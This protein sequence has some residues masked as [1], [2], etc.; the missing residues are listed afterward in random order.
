MA[1]AYETV[2]DDPAAAA[3]AERPRGDLDKSARERVE[4]IEKQRAGARDILGVRL[5]GAPDGDVPGSG[6]DAPP[7]TSLMTFGAV[8]FT[9]RLRGLA[10]F[11]RVAEYR[12]PLIERVRLG[13]VRQSLG[14][15]AET[16]SVSGVIHPDF[17]GGPQDVQTL[18]DAGAEPA[19]LVDGAG[20]NLGLWAVL[21]VEETWT[22]QGRDGLPRRIAFNA[23]FGRVG[24]DDAAGDLVDEAL[25]AG[26]EGDTAAA[27][28]A[29]AAA[30]AASGG[31]SRAAAE[32]AIRTAAESA[33]DGQ[34][35][36]RVLAAVLAAVGRGPDALVA[37]ARRAALGAATRAA[38]GRLTANVAYRARDGDALDAI[39]R[40]AYG[41]ESAVADLLAANPGAARTPVLRAGRL[42]GLPPVDPPRALKAVVRLWS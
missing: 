30:A 21:R 25:A 35:P 19:R 31:L 39:A 12:Y 7:E 27:V 9:T 23:E 18:R 36:K 17:S 41:A 13:P 24:P 3:T 10:E 40:A 28:D 15:G 4:L 16:V 29:V 14:P 38:H 37:A 33:A 1:A 8:L 42:I 11:R 34:G 5:P 6:E 2:L 22:R 26:A 32:S 20:R